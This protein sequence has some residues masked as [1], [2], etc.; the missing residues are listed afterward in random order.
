[1]NR[2]EMVLNNII[3][4]VYG[5]IRYSANIIIVVD[6]PLQGSYGSNICIPPS[7]TNLKKNYDTTTA[8]EEGYSPKTNMYS[9]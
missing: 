4:I 5:G 8:E 1:M 2:Y 3:Y 9:G 6:L 7:D